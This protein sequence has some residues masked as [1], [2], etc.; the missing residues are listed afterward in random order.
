MY[1]ERKN[2]VKNPVNWK[3]KHGK[4]VREGLKIKLARECGK[5]FKE[6]KWR[7]CE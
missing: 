6:G 1:Q 2:R 7:I 3:S 5:D 4:D